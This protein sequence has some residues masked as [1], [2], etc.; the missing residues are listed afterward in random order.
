MAA[1][2]VLVNLRSPTM[3]E[4]SGSVIRGLAL[5]KSMLVSDV[6]WFSEIP[7][8]A[9]LKIPVD[10][11]EVPT[12]AAALE[13]A[14]DRGAS[15]GAAASRYVHAEHDLGRVADAYTAALEEAAGGALVEDAVLRRVAESAA[16][17][18][19]ADP[20]ELARLVRESGLA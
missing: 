4:T 13:L 5:G 3:G 19:L 11:Y 14:A 2:D 8:N 20:A 6:G 18:G 1:C 9:V 12:I 10:E 17:I 16:G 15:L 7:D